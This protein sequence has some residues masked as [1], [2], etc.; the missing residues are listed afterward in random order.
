M[1]NAE[2]SLSQA[3]IKLCSA[4]GAAPAMHA[5]SQSRP[6]GRGG[7]ASAT[8]CM[9]RQS[10]LFARSPGSDTTPGSRRLEAECQE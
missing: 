9:Y 5:Q 3:Q 6:L 2:Q 4:C 10:R 8:V 1:K 7:L